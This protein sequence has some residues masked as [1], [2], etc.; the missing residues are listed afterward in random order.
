MQ[1]QNLEKAAKTIIKRLEME[2]RVCLGEVV[3]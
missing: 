3:K 1:H 2:R